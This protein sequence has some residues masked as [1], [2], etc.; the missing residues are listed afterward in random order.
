MN[1]PITA[2]N[3]IPIKTISQNPLTKSPISVSVGT[4]QPSIKESH[5]LLKDNRFSTL[6]AL[7]DS[8]SHSHSAP[9]VAPPSEMSHNDNIH[10]LSEAAP[11]KL[12]PSA[13]TPFL[14]DIPHHF[15]APTLNTNGSSMDSLANKTLAKKNFSPAP[16]PSKNK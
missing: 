12:S 1:E 3:P 9:D 15:S 16:T 2:S 8:E 14:S 4:P 11:S 6:D 13:N 7:G 5:H 10:P